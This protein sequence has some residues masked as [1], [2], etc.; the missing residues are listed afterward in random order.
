MKIDM[1]C[2]WCGGRLDQGDRQMSC[3]GCGTD[4]SNMLVSETRYEDS[5]NTFLEMSVSMD[6]VKAAPRCPPEIYP[7][8][9]GKTPV[10]CE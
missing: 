4:F 2:V 5:K 3:P 7:I 6:C 9:A 1:F 8:T 10:A